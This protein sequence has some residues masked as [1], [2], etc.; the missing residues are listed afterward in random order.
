M[1]AQAIA[2]TD[3]RRAILDAAGPVFGEHGYERASVDAIAAAAG[4]SKPT[5]YTYFGNKERLFRET[6]SDI[7]RQVNEASYEAVV[8]LD[9]HPERWRDSLR[10]L[11]LALSRC[12]REGCAASLSRLVLAESRRDPT[13]FEEVRRAGAEPI[14]EA[15]AGRLAMLGN[16]GLLD[17]DD[18]A[19]AARHFIAL[20]QAQLPE[21]TVGGT[22]P[23]DERLIGE[24]V[25]AGF[26]AFLRAY[27]V[28]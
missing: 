5:V 3:K 17:V 14:R 16:A 7:A 10:T 24:S 27:A 26:E 23:G 18:P 13:V 19:A 11:A 22:A 2:R 12:G 6:M 9:T 21:L 28:R 15:L 1:L 25:D 4:V 20:T 8:A